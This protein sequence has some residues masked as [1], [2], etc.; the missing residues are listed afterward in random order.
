MSPKISVASS[1]EWLKS[2]MQILYE[3]FWLK[4]KKKNP[5]NFIF[6]T[7]STIKHI[8]GVANSKYFEVPYYITWIPL[9][10]LFSMF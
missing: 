10:Q 2:Y 9:K 3:N 8:E 6:V 1:T 7:L 4:K 5:F